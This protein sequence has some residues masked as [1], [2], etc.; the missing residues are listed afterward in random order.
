MLLAGLDG[1]QN[2]IDPGEPLDKD[3]Y[4]LS[5]EQLKE[6]PSLP[7]S[8]DESL[9]ALETDH[10]FLLKGDVFT[11]ELL[12][13]WITYNG[14]G[15]FNR[16]DCDRIRWNSG[17]TL[18]SDCALQMER[19]GVKVLAQRSTWTRSWLF[20][21]TVNQIYRHL[22]K[23]LLW[24]QDAKQYIGTART[25]NRNHHELFPEDNSHVC[26]NDFRAGSY[27][28]RRL[29]S[30]PHD[31]L[32]TISSVL[33]QAINEE[34]MAFFLIR[35]LSSDIRP[36]QMGVAQRRSHSLEG[37]QYPRLGPTRCIYG[38]G[39]FE[40]MRCYETAEGPAVFCLDAHLER[41]Y[42]SASVHGIEV[43][44]TREELVRAICEVIQRNEFSSC[45]VRPLC[46]YGSST[47]GLHPAKCPVEVVILTWPWA[48]YLGA[49]G[50]E[51]GVRVTVSPWLKFHSQM[52]PT[53]AKA[54]GQYLNSILAVRDAVRRGF[55]EALLLDKDG[56]I[57]E[58]SGENLFIVRDRQLLTNDERHSILLG[59][60]RDVV[61]QQIARDLGYRLETGALR[62]DDLLKCR[63]GIL[64]GNGSRGY[65]YSRS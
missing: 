33:N 41:L 60:T 31:G 21:I 5:P 49:E 25:L 35:G 59:I 13:R 3:I 51:R 39:V 16:S 15:R 56:H 6:V 30:A 43:P 23:N 55:D 47:L 22:R 10:E 1:I 52:M 27:F 37:S 63:R 20:S 2:R 65:S 36:N 4:D 64:H 29:S 8:L 18:T 45:Y 9:E 57:A 26:R 62:L 32:L 58:G 40:G 38:S 12:E 7:G 50:L 61:M 34:L 11:P 48:A 46:F 28:F 44:Y 19:V 24:N 54:C 53:T 42:N 14:N 17:C